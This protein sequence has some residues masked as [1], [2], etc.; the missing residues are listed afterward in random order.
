[1]KY[2]KD[3]LSKYPKYK[4]IGG[5]KLKVILFKQNVHYVRS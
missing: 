4:R 2:W 5:D 3:R 1:M